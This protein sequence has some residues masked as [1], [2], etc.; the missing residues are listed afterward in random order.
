MNNDFSANLQA[1]MAK[2]G[3]D[4]DALIKG[5]V[6]IFLVA[7]IPPT[8]KYAIYVAS[9]IALIWTLK[10]LEKKGSS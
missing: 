7:I 6:L 9:F 3:P 2:L 10:A 8:R 4:L 1:Q 5:L